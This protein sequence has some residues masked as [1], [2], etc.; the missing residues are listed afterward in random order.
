MEPPAT[1]Q[2]NLPPLYFEGPLDDDRLEPPPPDALAT[3]FGAGGLGVGVAISAPS[4]PGT[5]SVWPMMRFGS[6]SS[7]AST[8]SDGWTWYFAASVSRV[9]L[10]PTV[11]TTPLT[12]GIVRIW[13]MWRSS[14][15]RR[16]LAHQT[17]IIVTSNLRA[18]P[19]SVS[20]DRT[21]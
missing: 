5:V 2:A 4:A 12:G 18:M 10:A 19:V 6:L 9:S 20:P 15:A 21:R 14:L 3:G 8:I 13:P 1:G 7:F 17:V 16:W 11:T